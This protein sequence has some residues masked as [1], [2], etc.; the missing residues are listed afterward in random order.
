M[1]GGRAGEASTSGRPSGRQVPES[2]ATQ[3]HTPHAPT[4]RPRTLLL[5][6]QGLALGA[7]RGRSVSH[8]LA[9]LI[10]VLP[11][12]LSS[13]PSLLQLLRGGL[14]RLP[15]RRK[16]RQPRLGALPSSVKRRGGGK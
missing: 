3:P 6:Q 2:S 12:L 15:Q 10:N 9:Q 16:L 5:L 1:E 4:T 14:V 8:I 13:V 7:A 11:L